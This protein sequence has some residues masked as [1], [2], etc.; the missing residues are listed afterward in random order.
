MTIR[1]LTRDAIL[2]AIEEFDRLGRTQFL[3]KYGFR[4]SKN[5]FLSLNGKLYDSKAIVGAAVGLQHPGR[6]PL[7]AR[8]FS[9]GQGVERVL[10]SLGFEVNNGPR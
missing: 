7:S 8:S 4:E 3:A 5:R 9:G 2:Q 1:G 10:Q 6:G